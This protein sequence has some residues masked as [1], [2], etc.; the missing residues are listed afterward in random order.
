MTE[1]WHGFT[2][3]CIVESIGVIV[4]AVIVAGA[5]WWREVNCDD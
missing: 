1:F 4:V 3:G 2:W 5:L